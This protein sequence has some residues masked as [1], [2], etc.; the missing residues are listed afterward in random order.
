M[1]HKGNGGWR[2]V[3]EP[4]ALQLA[5]RSDEAAA[6]LKPIVLA[7][8]KDDCRTGTKVETEAFVQRF[9]EA[10]DP[11]YKEQ[12]GLVVADLVA[13]G[14]EVSS[15]WELRDKARGTDGAV[16]VL[17]QW[18]ATSGYLPLKRNLAGL[19]GSTWAKP[20]A[21]V[22][23]VEEFRR[24]S[25][26][27]PRKRTLLVAIGEAFS[28][29]VDETSLNDAVSIATDRAF[30]PYRRPFAEAVGKMA[31]G[32]LRLV[33]VLLQ[34]GDDPE[35]VAPAVLEAVSALGLPQALPAVE[36][37][38]GHPYIRVHQAAMKTVAHLRRLAG[39]SG[40]PSGG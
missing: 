16:S 11:I 17:G 14:V 7:T 10:Y 5:G 19:L 6:S 21:A 40:L 39:E 23:L 27:D 31:P 32:A 18:L 30:G 28:R 29:V 20:T 12:A 3:L 8:W 9:N 1:H 2:A 13:A 37:L 36:K 24:R 35:A 26:D 4:V 34:L 25:K 22:F 38:V 33:P 15:L